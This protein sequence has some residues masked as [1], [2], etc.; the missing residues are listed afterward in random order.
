MTQHWRNTH[1]DS[2]ATREEQAVR[3]AISRHQSVPGGLLPL[4]HDVQDTLGYVPKE[5]TP[6]IAAALNLSRADVHG[7][8]TYYHHFRQTPPAGHTLAICE[9][10][11]CQARGCRSLVKKAE[12]LLGCASGETTADQR[13]HLEPVYCLGL[14]ASGPAL[15]LDGKLHGRVTPERLEMLVKSKNKELS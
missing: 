14:C 7:V 5:A 9:A 1:L 3:D 13:W 10:E 4:L 11:A 6:A 2:K 12:A 8:I 15:V